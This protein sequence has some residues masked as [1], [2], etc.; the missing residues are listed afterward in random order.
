MS[1]AA[2]FSEIQSSVLISLTVFSIV[3]LLTAFIMLCMMLL[4]KACG[5]TEQTKPAA[6][7]EQKTCETD[8]QDEEIA[9]VI[10]AAIMQF[11]S[12]NARVVSFRPSPV[13]APKRTMWSRFGRIQNFENGMKR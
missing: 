4:H 9:A 13:S 6:E 10:T 11:V 12:E 5:K 2:A 7:K 1:L 3:F 8:G